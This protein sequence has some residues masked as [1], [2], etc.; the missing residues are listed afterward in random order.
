M[1]FKSSS[2]LTLIAE[3]ATSENGSFRAPNLKNTKFKSNKGSA[4]LSKFV[5]IFQAQFGLISLLYYLMLCILG[6]S[7]AS[8]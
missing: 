3:P 1:R 7:Q 4:T 6:A 2:V 8:N 5:L